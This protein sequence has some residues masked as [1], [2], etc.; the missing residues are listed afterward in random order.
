[1]TDVLISIKPKY[2]NMILSGHK[3]VEIRTRRLKLQ[4]GTRLWIYS[5]L[6][7]A[8]LEAVAVVHSTK[9][10]APNLIWEH[11]YNKIGI[12]RG[13]FLTYVNGSKQVSAIFLK[14][15]RRLVPSLTLHDLR[16]EIAGFNPPQFLSCIKPASTFF[17]VL[18]SRGV[19]FTSLLSS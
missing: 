5:T 15:V 1:M 7:R 12:P 11:Y 18:G 13:T 9:F 14:D 2:V 6:P 10:D 17:R 16:A 19:E 8:C 3:T 4:P